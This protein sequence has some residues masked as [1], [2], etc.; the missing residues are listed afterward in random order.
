MIDGN[1][2]DN[3]CSSIKNVGISGFGYG[4]FLASPADMIIES[5]SFGFNGDGVIITNGT[6]TGGTPVINQVRF[7][8]CQVSYNY[9]NQFHI[10]FGV[11]IDIGNCDIAP[12]AGATGY[13]IFLD[14]RGEVNVHDL[15][16]EQSS[17]KPNI[18]AT[19]QGN[20]Q[21]SVSLYLHDMSTSV[22]LAGLTANTYSVIATNAF[23][24]FGNASL[25]NAADNFFNLLINGDLANVHSEYGWRTRIIAGGHIITNIV[26]GTGNLGMMNQGTLSGN[27][28]EGDLKRQFQG[29]DGSGVYA[30]SSLLFGAR[31]FDFDNST[32]INPIDLLGYYKDRTV[33]GVGI[34]STNGF[35]TGTGTGRTPILTNFTSYASGTA[36][37]LTGSAA[38][39]AFGTTSPG[40]TIQNGG[41]YLIQGSVGVKYNGATY[42][43]AQTITLKFRRTNNTAT[44][45]TSGS[46][47]VELPVLTT[48]TGGDVMNLPSVVYTATAG[49]IVQ[50]F[51]VVS[52]TPSAGSV[53]TDSAELLAIRLF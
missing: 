35:I 2:T 29:F 10:C 18:V 19:D 20:G 1:T 3:D 50:I 13:G 45:L 44:D 53:Q 7:T 24:Y 46:R 23:L 11:H 6:F 32:S 48:F 52:A 15:H 43:G 27:I 34:S 28:N 40:I 51:G 37:T 47:T 38:Q 16:M 14:G 4:L 36:Y 8:G 41:T 5:C 49:D 21:N 26:G 30:L 31:T 42:A 9:T 12:Q 17:G 22:D 39:L 33:N 25:Q